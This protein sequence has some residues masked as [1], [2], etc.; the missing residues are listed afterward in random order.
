MN[1]TT[2]T[3][4]RGACM[5]NEIFEQP[6]VLSNLLNSA[7]PILKTVR[8]ELDTRKPALAV[9]TARGSSDNASTYGKYLIES[10]LRL[11]T[12]L[13]APSLFTLFDTPPRL[14]QTFVVGVSQSGGSVDVVA[15]VEDAR[16]Q[17]ALTMGVTNVAGSLLART[18]THTVLLNAGD[19]RALAA[20]KT[21]TAQCLTYAMLTDVA[22]C[23]QVPHEVESALQLD[24]QIRALAQTWLGV[25]RAVVIGRGFN[26]G[27]AQE[28]ALKLKETCFISAEPYS[29][30]DFMHGPL[31][32]VEP[33]FHMLVL[34][35]HDQTLAPTLELIKRAKD[36]GAALTIIA[37]RDAARH[38]EA[39][40]IVECAALTS[41][42]AFITIGQLLALNLSLAKGYDPDVSRGVS[43]VT[44]TR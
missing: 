18:A 12:A 7:R 6:Q 3:T 35:N 39:N 17:G 28:I 29:A 34:V 36:R 25:Q 44:I 8:H 1:K 27:A 26:F 21:V 2:N 30:A 9:L 4:E 22:E 13:A 43:K 37:T 41:T 19:E 31:A 15:V 38:T 42:I 33:D 5:R 24:A 32:L 11:P 14:D 40:L 23:A 16:R 10:R 20:T